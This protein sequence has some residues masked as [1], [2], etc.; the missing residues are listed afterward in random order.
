MKTNPRDPLL[1]VLDRE[2]AIILL[3]DIC[4]WLEEYR[5]NVYGD[6]I[7]LRLNGVLE[8]EDDGAITDRAA[9]LDRAIRLGE[10]RDEARRWAARCYLETEQARRVARHWKQIAEQIE[11]GYLEMRDRAWESKYGGKDERV[12]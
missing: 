2:S 4:M 9:V 8:N 1:V 6:R 3:K 7:S 10:E 5:P 11:H 12:S